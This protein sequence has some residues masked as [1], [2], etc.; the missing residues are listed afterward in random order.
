MSSPHVSCIIPSALR[1]SPAGSLWLERAIRSVQAQ[2]LP[3]REI[4]VGLDPG[5]HLPGSIMALA[6]EALPIRQANGEVKG[7]QSAC[8]AAAA[9]AGCPLLA[10]LEDDDEWL[11]HHLATLAHVLDT[12]SVLFVSTSQLEVDTDGNELKP[13]DFP[14]ASGWLLTRLLWKQQGGFD[15]RWQIAHDNEFLGRLNVAGVPRAHVVEAGAVIEQRPHLVLLAPHARIIRV[16]DMPRLSVRRTMHA[17]SIMGAMTAGDKPKQVRYTKEC[18]AL[19][20]LYG[21]VAW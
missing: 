17:A 12:T 21:G 10:F 19:E 5:E 11:P 3:P 15:T 2:A 8:N 18:A 4:L 20:V 6:S 7:H 14:T 9:R 13:F 1:S 16:D